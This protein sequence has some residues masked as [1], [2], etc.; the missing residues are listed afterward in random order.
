MALLPVLGYILTSSGPLNIIAY[1]M[2][3]LY[4]TLAPTAQQLQSGL[5][6]PAFL[7]DTIAASLDKQV[8][9]AGVT[10]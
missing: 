9:L 10:S 6:N 2:Y 4:T 3:R 7:P 8:P 5:H 1:A